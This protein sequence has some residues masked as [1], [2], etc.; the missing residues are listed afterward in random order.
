MPAYT[1][2][3]AESFDFKLIRYEKRDLRA[4]VTFNR[5]DV[6]N[7]VNG[8]ML[9]ELNAAFQDASWDDDVRVLIPLSRAIVGLPMF[10][11]RSWHSM[12]R[13]IHFQ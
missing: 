5:P 4:I 11:R 8:D 2:K 12:K 13:P 9:V 1:G 10:R 6:L 7:A 3:P